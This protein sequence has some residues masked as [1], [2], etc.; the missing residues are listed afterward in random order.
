MTKPVDVIVINIYLAAK[1]L[2]DRTD[3]DENSMAGAHSFKP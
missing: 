2:V 3:N 1:M